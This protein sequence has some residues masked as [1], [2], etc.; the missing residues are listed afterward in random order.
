MSDPMLDRV[1]RWVARAPEIRAVILTGSRAA[2]GGPPD[3][4]ADYDII[5]AVTDPARFADGDLSW[6]GELGIPLVRWGDDGELLGHR[7]HFRGVVYDDLTKVDFTI[8]PEALLETIA[9]GEPP[10]ALDHGYRVLHDPS[11]RTRGWA[12]PTFSAHVLRRPS[13]SEYRALVEQFWWDTTYVAKAVR[14]DDL[15]FATSWVLEHDLKVVALRRMLEWRIAAASGWTF[16]PGVYGR[17]LEPHLDEHDRRA[18]AATCASL[19]ADGAWHALFAVTDL[20]RAAAHD[21]AS[22]LGFVYPTG[23]DERMTARLAMARAADRNRP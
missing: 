1:Q 15:F 22:A 12:A 5:L 18:L 3:D 14:R 7:T 9:A 10:P 2:Q 6:H 19:D 21:V 4:M 13:E 23:I 8:W 11:G 16:A 17:G 20:F